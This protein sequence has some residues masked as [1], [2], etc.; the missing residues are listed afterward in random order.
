MDQAHRGATD[1]MPVLQESVL[2]QTEDSKEGGEVD[3]VLQVCRLDP[4]MILRCQCCSIGPEHCLVYTFCEASHHPTQPARCMNC[5]SYYNKCQL[6][7]YRIPASGIS[8]PSWKATAAICPGLG[9]AHR[10]FRNSPTL[11]E[12]AEPEGDYYIELDNEIEE[13]LKKWLKF[14]AQPPKLAETFQARPKSNAQWEREIKLWYLWLS[15]RGDAHTFESNEMRG[16]SSYVTLEWVKPDDSEHGVSYVVRNGRVT[17][18]QR[19][20]LHS[21]SWAKP[22]NFRDGSQNWIKIPKRV[23]K[24]AIGHSSEGGRRVAI[25][26]ACGGVV[27]VQGHRYCLNCGLMPMSETVLQHFETRYDYERNISILDLPK[28]EPKR[29]EAWKDKILKA[30]LIHRN[31]RTAKERSQAILAQEEDLD[32]NFEAYASPMDNFEEDGGIPYSKDDYG[33]VSYDSDGYDSSGQLLDAE[34]RLCHIRLDGT[35]T[36]DPDEAVLNRYQIDRLEKHHDKTVNP[37]KQRG[38]AHHPNKPVKR[39]AAQARYKHDEAIKQDLERVFFIGDRLE[40][41]FSK[42]ETV[43]A[44]RLD[45][46]K[47]PLI[48]LSPPKILKEGDHLELNE[49]NIRPNFYVTKPSEKHRKGGKI[50]KK[51]SHCKAKS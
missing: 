39:P 42:K 47:R 28:L 17:V 23:R 34:Y 22:Y 25:C 19:E 48:D 20:V 29:L 18:F 13:G 31:A 30:G 10:Y 33:E 26:P 15:H 35:H 27:M 46:G 32:V 9:R 45:Q 4:S 51:K 1:N 21:M 7:A 16:V 40:V 38:K 5:I 8:L 49:I 2:G 41:C 37:S 24:E 3:L 44:V 50:K 12:G 11:H 6:Y 14:R 36:N 43:N